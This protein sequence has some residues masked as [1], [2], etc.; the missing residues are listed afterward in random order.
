MDME[1][2]TTNGGWAEPP[3]SEFGNAVLKLV[4]NKIQ[5]VFALLRDNLEIKPSVELRKV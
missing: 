5:K 1:P 4:G 2:V 3:R